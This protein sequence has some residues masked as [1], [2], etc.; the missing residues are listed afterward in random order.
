MEMA[1]TCSSFGEARECCDTIASDHN[2]GAANSSMALRTQRH[3]RSEGDLKMLLEVCEA[4]TACVIM[5]APLYGAKRLAPRGG[6][7]LYA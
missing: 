3:V 1:T 6:A 5:Q 7:R 4:S 2:G